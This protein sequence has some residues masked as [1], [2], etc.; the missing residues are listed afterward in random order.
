MDILSNEVERHEELH[1]LIW[2]MYKDVYGIRPRHMSFETMT[3]AQLEAEVEHLSGELEIQVAYERQQ[4]IAAAVEFEA[5]VKA[6]IECGA[7][8]RATALRWIHDAEG[9]DGD[10]EYLCYCVGLRY[11]YFNK[12]QQRGG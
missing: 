2:D 8:D 3:V 11:G 1:S 6:L 7:G 10:D 12:E 9:T 4:H 5:R